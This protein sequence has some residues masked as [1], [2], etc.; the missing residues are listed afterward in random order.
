MPGENKSSNGPTSRLLGRVAPRSSLA[1]KNFMHVGARVIDSDYRGE[2]GVML[3]NFGDKD[4]VVNMGD[5]I[6]QLIFEKIKTHKI[7]ETNEL[8]G[9]GRGTGSYGN[10]SVNATKRNE[11]AVSGPS[12]AND[13]MNGRSEKDNDDVKNE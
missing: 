11:D 3:F 9:T 13:Q 12:S 10:T 2:L 5:R 7:K 8:E 6:V 1:I 4:F